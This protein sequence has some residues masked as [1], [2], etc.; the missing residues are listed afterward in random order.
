MPLPCIPLVC[1][2]LSS[3][4]QRKLFARLTR[5]RLTQCTALPM[6]SARSTPPA[7]G[8]C[9]CCTHPTQPPT[10][11]ARTFHPSHPLLQ[12]S[13]W[14]G[15]S[16]GTRR[17]QGA[18]CSCGTPSTISFAPSGP[19]QCEARVSAMCVLVALR[20]SYVAGEVGVGAAAVVP[21]ARSR[22]A[23]TVGSKLTAAAARQLS[24]SWAQDHTLWLGSP[25]QSGWASRVLQ[26][27]G[28]GC[29]SGRSAGMLSSRAHSL[30]VP[31]GSRSA[32]HA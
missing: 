16:W 14:R 31:T 10:P 21:W 23:A 7:H 8:Q 2:P 26:R 6:D 22:A 25:L 9:A 12:A 27:H 1:V 3:T 15:R 13:G 24:A 30:S 17:Q 11:P 19:T 18:S 32:S 20:A 28:G 4:A 5:G 29:R